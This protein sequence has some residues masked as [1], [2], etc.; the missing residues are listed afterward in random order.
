MSGK[1]S[2]QQ[3]MFIHSESASTIMESWFISTP[4]FHPAEPPQDISW[5]EHIVLRVG[6]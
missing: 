1:T 6:R 4:A 3:I 5:T 2:K